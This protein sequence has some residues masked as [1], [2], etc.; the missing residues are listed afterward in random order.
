MKKTARTFTPETIKSVVTLINNRV[1]EI[2]N[3]EPAP[4][5][6]VIDKGNHK[7]GVNIPVFNLPPVTTCGGNC[8]ACVSH[9]YAIK[10]YT[11]YRVKAV[12]TNH[13]RNVAALIQDHTQA[14]IDLDKYFTRRAPDFFRVHASGDF[15][16]TIN[17][18]ALLYAKMWY[19]I[20]VSHPETRFLAFTKCYEIARDVPF[21]N[22]GNFELVLSEWTDV[23]QA[24]ADL[25]KR[26]RTSRAVESLDDVRENEIICPGNCETCGACWSLS[27]IGRD[28]AFEIH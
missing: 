1:D 27:R 11:N 25:K 15:A 4:R 20:A 7:T 22:T 16:L 14:G 28:V 3:T 18:D 17:G 5:I 13:C 6:K 24:P 19:N 26:Y 23:L 2:G 9:C 8:A 10:D 21:D 12:S